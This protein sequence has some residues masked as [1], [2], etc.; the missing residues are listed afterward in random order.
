MTKGD[1]EVEIQKAITE[2]SRATIEWKKIIRIEDEE[3][4]SS[5]SSISMY[6]L[7]LYMEYLDVPSHPSPTLILQGAPIPVH[8]EEVHRV[9]EKIPS[10]RNSVIQEKEHPS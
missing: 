1:K 9:I 2:K 6:N 4:S 10:E 7:D 3:S 8:L 5:S